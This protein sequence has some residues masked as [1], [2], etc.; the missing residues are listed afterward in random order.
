MFDL[1][2]QGQA[3]FLQI[4]IIFKVSQYRYIIYFWFFELF[5]LD[6]VRINI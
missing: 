5:D 2:F 3:T 4:Y 6:Y 1:D